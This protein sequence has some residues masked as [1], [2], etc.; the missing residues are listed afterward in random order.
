MRRRARGEADA[1]LMK[2]QA[3]AAGMREILSKQAEGFTEIV[4]SA[5]GEASD[6]I[7]LMLADK[8][9]EL[10]RIQVDA[11]KNLK[12]DKITVWDN[13]TGSADGKTSTANFVSGLMKSVPP[14]NEIFDMAGMQLPEYLGKKAEDA[15]AEETAE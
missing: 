6:A 7:R 3:E 15:P 5:G 11:I 9:E 8:M 14:L 10:T 1:I 12:I 2:M 4:N 13:G